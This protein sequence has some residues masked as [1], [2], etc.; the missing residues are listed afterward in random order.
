MIE[1]IRKPDMRVQLGQLVLKNPVMTASGCFGFGREYRNFFDLNILGAMVVKGTTLSPRQGNPPPRL[2]ETPA[3]L[4]NAIGLQNPGVDRVIAEELPALTGVTPPVIVNVAGS[5]PKEYVEVARRLAKSPVVAALE[6]NV[7]C[8]NVAKGGMTLGTCPVQVESLVKSIRQ[9]FPRTLI[10]KLTPNVTD[11]R[12][13]AL[14]AA[15]GGADA[16]SL[17]NTLAGMVIDVETQRPLLGNVSGGLSG[18]ALRP[19]AVRMVWQV[20]EVVDLPLIGM[21]GITS[22]EDALQF[23]LAGASA[24][25]IGTGGLVDPSVFQRVLTGLEEYLVR[26]EIPSIK[27]ICGLAHKKA[28]RE[29][30]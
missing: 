18:P 28:V 11:I 29:G 4:L 23:I 25:A 27:D 5:S 9:V 8:P 14:G 13:I 1:N 20:A 30:L 7:S 16:L 10:V 22:A 15:R 26:K 17:I 19:V 3:G 2:A 12:E 6:V 24:V 21:G